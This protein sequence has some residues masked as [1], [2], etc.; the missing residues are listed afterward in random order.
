M[1]AGSAGAQTPAFTVTLDNLVNL[2]GGGTTNVFMTGSTGGG[3]VIV[4]KAS[5]SRLTG[6]APLYVNIDMTDTTSTLSTNPA[7]ELFYSINWGDSGAG[8]WANGVQ[9]AGLTDKNWSFGPVGGHV[10]E[11]P[12]TY[13]VTPTA[14]DGGNTA[15]RTKTI[16]VLDPNVVYQPAYGAGYETICIS[17][18]NNFTGAPGT[19]GLPGVATYINRSGDTD[20]YAAWVAHKASNKRILFCKA[21]TWVASATIDAGGLSDMIVGGYGTGTAH[22]FATGTTLVSVTPAVGVA[23]AIQTAGATNI[24]FCEFRIN[25]N[26]TTNGIGASTGTSTQ[27]TVFKTEVY[28][29]TESFT[30]DPGSGMN[31]LY[32]HEQSCFY[33]CRSDELY[34]YAFW[35]QPVDSAAGAIGTPGVFTAVEHVFNRF[36]KVQLSGS[37][38][39][40]LSTGVTYYIS[41]TNLTADT[42]SLS[43]APFPDTP[44]A[45]S[46]TGTCTVTGVAANGGSCG[47]ITLTKGAIMGCYFDNCNRGEQTLR[48]QHINTSHITNNY[49]ARPNQTKNIIKIHNR[50][51]TNTIGVSDGYAQKIVISGNELDLRGGY[52]NNEVIPN[53]GT[54]ATR[55]GTS[56]VVTGYGN[57]GEGDA[58]E[59]MQHVIFENNITYA[60]LGNP[61]GGNMVVEVGCRDFTVRNNIADFSIGDRTTADAGDYAFTN[62][63][64]A[65]IATSTEQQTLRV[66]V[67]NNTM[68]SNHSGAESMYFTRLLNNA[69]GAFLDA[70]EITIK[71]NLWYAPFHGNIK[72]TA[73]FN[74]DGAC[75]PTITASNNTDDGQTSATTP[76]FAVQPPVALAD[77]RPTTGYAV[78][79]GAT[80]PVLR[81]FNMATRSGL[82]DL[83]AVLP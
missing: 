70:D 29:A 18:S 7:H 24:R 46:G 26:A 39:A 45:L 36:N 78:D 25:A 81:D 34:G 32:K 21:D 19:A 37:V 17:H 76:N 59:F 8:Q 22:T 62:T 42:F 11:T 23:R 38:P 71:N 74:Q 47:Y 63:C 15:N 5:A 40:P 6:V 64:F 31:V 58:K 57:S 72:R 69:N 12:G 30:N 3:G 33:E 20:M 49:F 82:Y 66:Y 68:Y 1:L 13:V 77:W 43:A 54:V 83:G 27:V 65:T 9:S 16:V 28:G 48:V 73:Y 50:S 75:G 2:T 44:L 80:V 41:G 52:S 67:Y 35:D 53:N 14:T 51:Y 79:G 60:C 61:R 56:S 10:F 4:A 55:V